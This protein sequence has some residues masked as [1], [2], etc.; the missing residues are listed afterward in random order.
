M[1]KSLMAQ[2]RGGGRMNDFIAALEFI[3]TFTLLVQSG[4]G[5]WNRMDKMI[6]HGRQK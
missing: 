5:I 6:L 2:G 1:Q 3:F 4:Q